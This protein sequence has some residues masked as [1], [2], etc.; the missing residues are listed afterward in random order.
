M[1][2]AAA[3]AAGQHMMKLVRWLRFVLMCAHVCVC[4]ASPRGQIEHALARSNELRAQRDALLESFR[5]K[6][7]WGDSLER[8]PFASYYG[9]LLMQPTFACP[10]ETLRSSSAREHHAG[11]SGPQGK[12][13]CGLRSRLRLKPLPCSVLSFGSNFEWSF[14]RFVQNLASEVGHDPCRIHTVDPTLGPKRRVADFRAVLRKANV[15]LHTDAGLS[16][17][18]VPNAP[19][20]VS[21]PHGGS[22]FAVRGLRDFL[23][24]TGGECVDVLKI[25]AEGVELDALSFDHTAPPHKRRPPP[26]CAGLLL[27]EL[28]ATP[29]KIG[30]ELSV[31]TAV[32]FAQWLEQAG[33]HHFSSELQCAHCM[34]YTELG[35][36]NVSW[37][38]RSMGRE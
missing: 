11:N 26:W 19:A 24:R 18:D 38:Q 27:L 3:T 12:W 2:A 31:A 22:K 15:T 13:T 29:R 25:D 32:E 1:G 6:D 33:M 37:L 4:S 17:R 20:W 8:T 36:V 7:T 14:E 35:F 9:P 5:P 34:G 21:L 30:F 23:S 28:H 16:R 10:L